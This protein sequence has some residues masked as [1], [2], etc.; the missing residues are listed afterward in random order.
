MSG[1]GGETKKIYAFLGLCA[2]AGGLTS[3]E[4]AV[5]GAVRA[6]KAHLV[7]V[8]ED[9]SENTKKLY[10][11][12]CASHDTKRLCFGEAERLGGAI[13]KNKRSAVAVCDPHFA[14]ELES[15]IT[16]LNKEL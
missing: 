8:A 2:R 9:A 3:G 7:I 16:L 12:K 13:G 4:T 14:T 6:G 11:D 10:R 5:L 1:E 15:R